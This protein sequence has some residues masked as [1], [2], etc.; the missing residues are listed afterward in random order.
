MDLQS[1]RIDYWNHS[2]LSAGDEYH[3]ASNKIPKRTMVAGVSRKADGTI[4]AAVQDRPVRPNDMWVGY[5]CGA[6]RT[7]RAHLGRRRD[8]FWRPLLFTC[9]GPDRPLDVSSL[10]RASEKRCSH[11]SFRRRPAYLRLRQDSPPLGLRLRRF[12]LGRMLVFAGAM[13]RRYLEIGYLPGGV[14][15]AMNGEV[16]IRL[17]SCKGTPYSGRPPRGYSRR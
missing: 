6:L 16:A 15:R 3:R 2:P 13:G 14:I 17:L 9:V 12:D 8:G 1:R 7:R 11:F 4:A 10:W 5:R